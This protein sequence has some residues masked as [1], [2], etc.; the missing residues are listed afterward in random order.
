M[1]SDFLSV[2]DDKLVM[3]GK[4]ALPMIGFLF[5]LKYIFS[6]GFTVGFGF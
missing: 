5:V 4:I 1:A 6:F 3:L 2:V